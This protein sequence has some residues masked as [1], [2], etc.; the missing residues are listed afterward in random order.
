ML[1]RSYEIVSRLTLWMVGSLLG[2]LCPAVPFV[3]I[4]FFA[5]VLDCLSAYRLARR[6]KANHPEIPSDQIHDKFESAKA[7][8]VFGTLLMISSLIVLFHVMD[9]YIFTMA[10]LYLANW[11]AGGFCAVQAWSVL[12]NESSENG[13]SWARV[14]QKIMINKA[15]RHIEG[16]DELVNTIEKEN[17]TKTC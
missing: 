16:F 2:Q 7:S 12:E 15:K 17:E 4:C 6:V 14:L 8:K 11:V 5:V 1:E 13:S 10:H 3:L 9:E